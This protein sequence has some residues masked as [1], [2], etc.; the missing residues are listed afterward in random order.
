[1][2]APADG[3]RVTVTRAP[4]VRYRVAKSEPMSM[5]WVLTAAEERYVLELVRV[6]LHGSNPIEVAQALM[7]RGLLEAFRAGLLEAPGHVEVREL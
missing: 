4:K 1:M 3:S 5:V 6:G 2:A 7:R